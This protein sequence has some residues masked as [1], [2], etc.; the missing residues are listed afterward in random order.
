MYNNIWNWEDLEN[1]VV[2]LLYDD[3]PV[4]P[5]N[6][7]GTKKEEDVV[8]FG[9]IAQCKATEHNNMSLLDK[10]INRLLEASHMHDKLPLFVSSTWDK[11]GVTFI[12]D[13]KNDDTMAS[14]VKIAVIAKAAQRLKKMVSTLKSVR[15]LNAAKREL[16]KLK[17]RL[18]V[19]VNKINDTFSAIDTACETKYDDLTIVD[20][21]E[22]EKN[23]S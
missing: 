8:T 7:G 20:L 3:R 19:E 11:L 1:W 14:S 13:G 18:N 12:F 22:G 4:R 9:S 23:G 5:P 21:F 15:Q 17:S 6:S 10:D 2:Q 16:N